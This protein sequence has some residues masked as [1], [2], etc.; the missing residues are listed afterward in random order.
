MK[1]WLS[2]Y[3]IELICR[4]ND[5]YCENKVQVIQQLKIYQQLIPFKLLPRDCTIQTLLEAP[6]TAVHH[7]DVEGGC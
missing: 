5:L 4:K 6:I 3:A 7:K 1:H 2:E